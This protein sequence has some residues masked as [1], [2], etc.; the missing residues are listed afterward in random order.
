MQIL[1]VP[2][3]CLCVSLSVSSPYPHGLPQ[4]TTGHLLA[5]HDTSV[6]P[7]IIFG[8]PGTELQ[9]ITDSRVLLQGYLESVGNRAREGAKAYLPATLVTLVLAGT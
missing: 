4:K 6:C 9:A 7:Y 2:P 8:N 1:S 5:L 3:A